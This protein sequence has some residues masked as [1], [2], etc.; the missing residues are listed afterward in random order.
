MKYYI[1]IICTL[2]LFVG[3]KTIDTPLNTNFNDPD[4]ND[5]NINDS[6]PVIEYHIV[7]PAD[8]VFTKDDS[9][10]AQ[11]ITIWW[12]DSLRPSLDTVSKFLYEVGAIRYLFSDSIPDLKNYRF[13]TPWERSKVMIRF[14][15]LHTK[16]VLDSTYLEWNKF[17]EDLR[18]FRIIAYGISSYYFF[19]F[20]FKG[21]LHPSRLVDLYKNIPGVISCYRNIYGTI[22]TGLRSIYPF[23][24]DSVKTYLFV[25]TKDLAGSTFYYFTVLGKKVGMIGYWDQQKTK[26]VPFWWEDALENINFMKDKL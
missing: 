25:T 22:G 6:I 7:D 16:M 18:P 13:S 2:Y 24:K 9:I 17:D 5:I 12:T 21:V 11:H 26:E 23:Q 20:K 3:C 14:D 1:I 10:E 19:G 15:S 8:L 4:T